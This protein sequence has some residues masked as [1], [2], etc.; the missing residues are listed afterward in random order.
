MTTRIFEQNETFTTWHD[1]LKVIGAPP[2]AVHLASGDEYASVLR[3]LGVPEEDI[4]DVVAS[5]PD[6]NADAEVW[7]YLER[8]VYS[9]TLHMDALD[10]PPRIASLTDVNDPRWRYFFVHVYAAALPLV[11]PWFRQRGIPEDVVQATL[12]DLGR[13]VRVHRK[14]HGRGGLET[15]SWLML[16]FRGMIYQLGRL[17]FE[18]SCIANTMATRISET[19][20]HMEENDHALSLH[21]S[22]FSGPMSPEACDASIDRA[23]AFF[24]RFFPEMDFR[25]AY[26]NSWLLDPQLRSYLRPQSNII[27]FQNRFA[28][29]PG[30]YNVNRSIVQ[31]VFG[32]TPERLDE[33]PERS[34]LERAVVQHLKAG[35]NWEGRSGWFFLQ[36]AGQTCTPVP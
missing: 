12:A 28:L 20:T 7:W 6:P 30:A 3:Y 1:H 16:H 34:S 29:V 17:Q 8:T 33:L 4:N 22:D 18:R 14:R 11:Q 5:A 31:F 9:L 35:K 19:G 24:P 26:C 15:A 13:N 21:I 36:D 25:V 32:S 2:F 10:G 27:Q 23:K